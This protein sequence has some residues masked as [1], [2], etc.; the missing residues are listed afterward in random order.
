MASGS[1]YIV[2][3]EEAS[4]DSFGQDASKWIKRIGAKLINKADSIDE[5]VWEVE[6]SGISFWISYDDY[7]SSITLEP[8]VKVSDSTVERIA[9]QIE[10]TV[11]AMNK[12]DEGKPG[13]GTSKTLF[14]VA[15][16][17]VIFYLI[18]ILPAFGSSQSHYIQKYSATER[19]KAIIKDVYEN[20]QLQGRISAWSVLGIYSL[21]AC[22]FIGR[23]KRRSA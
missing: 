10:S 1:L 19:E 20:M 7:Q 5:R 23:H 17:Y 3:Q 22:S 15:T 12:T 6:Y 14:I 21:F 8:K 11:Y 18:S 16:I 2:L 4:W 13:G 9:A